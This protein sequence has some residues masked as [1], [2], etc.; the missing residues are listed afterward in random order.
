MKLARRVA[1]ASLGL[2]SLVACSAA[3]SGGGAGG[4]AT[5]SASTATT[6][7]STT[8][9]SGG[10]GAGGGATS[11]GGNGGATSAGGSGGATSAGGSGGAT[12]GGGSGGATSGGGSGGATSGGGSGG[13]TTTAW[14]AGP[15]PDDPCSLVVDF[16]AV[17]GGA[18][19]DGLAI[20]DQYAADYGVT[21]GL[22]ADGDGIAD[23]GK[24]PVLA[25]VGD[26]ATAFAYEQGGVGDTA[27]PGQHLG[28]FFLTD[29]GLVGGPHAALVVS[30][31]YLVSAAYG[32]LVDVDGD[33]AWTIEARGLSGKVLESIVIHAGDP[34]T[35][36]G[37]ARAWSF[38]RNDF[39]VRWLVV[40]Y[41]GGANSDGGLALDRFSPACAMP[42]I[43]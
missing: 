17:P 11:A 43:E 34:G 19:S 38:A 23:P 40:R 1:I 21:F 14:D 10:Q 3:G 20:T 33:E 8:G 25:M 29:D 35:G 12:S 42:A 7:A 15:F 30:Y 5:T 36:D 13:G 4:E 26:P 41:T 18:P 16:E 37:V 6:T 32:E 27:A 31:S 24:A 9:G 39:D 28:S 2:G 22:D